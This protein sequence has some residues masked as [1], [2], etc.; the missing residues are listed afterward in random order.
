MVETTS[1]EHGATEPDAEEVAA[2]R[3]PEKKLVPPSVIT[4]LDVVEQP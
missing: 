4:E 1:D 2:T 3:A